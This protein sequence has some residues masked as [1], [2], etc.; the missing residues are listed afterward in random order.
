[1]GGYLEPRIFFCLESNP[2]SWVFEVATWIQ[3]RAGP[4]FWL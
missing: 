1:M 4:A 3:Q 2:K